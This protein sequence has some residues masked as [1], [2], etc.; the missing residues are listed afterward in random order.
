MQFM[1]HYNDTY[2]TEKKLSGIIKN[3]TLFAR[4]FIYLED[5]EGDLY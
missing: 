4:M 5:F 3:C 2:S 1:T